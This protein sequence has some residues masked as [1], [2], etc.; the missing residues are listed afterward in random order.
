M[1]KWNMQQGF[2]LIEVLAAIVILSIVSLVL[3]SYFTNAMSY[4]K[5][6]QN[7]TIM[8]NLARNA[9]F[10]MEKQDFESLSE[11]FQKDGNEEIECAAADPT[12]SADPTTEPPAVSACTVFEGIAGDPEVLEKVLNPSINGIDYH[13]RIVYQRAVYNDLRTSTDPIDIATAEYLLPV[14]VMVS[15]V[16]DTSLVKQTVVEGYITNEE[17]R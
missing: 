16:R 6:N 3:T 9:L 15:D 8:V 14:E 2:T 12:V 10:Y 13:I 11:Y 7:K 17:I 4:S 5:S 1:F